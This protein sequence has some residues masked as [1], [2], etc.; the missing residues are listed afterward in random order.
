MVLCFVVTRV[1]TRPVH[2]R[3]GTEKLQAAGHERD[4]G[5]GV[6]VSAQRCH[7]GLKVSKQCIEVV[8]AANRILGIIKSSFVYKN[9][10]VMLQLYKSL[11]RPHVEYCV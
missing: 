4:L 2:R 11:L 6:I 10:Q 1:C 8:N 5:P 7:G 3:L 9:P